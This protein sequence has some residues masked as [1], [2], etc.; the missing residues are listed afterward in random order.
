MI[1]DRPACATAPA[2]AER[3]VVWP[4]RSQLRPDRVLKIGGLTP[5][6]ATDYPGHLSAVIFVQGCPWRCHY[7]HNPHLQPR[8]RHSPLSWPDL[9]DWLERRRGLLDAVVFCGGEPLMDPM[10]P[11]AVLEAKAMGFKIA[12]HSGGSYPAPL[13]KILPYLDWIGLDIKTGFD[14]YAD[15]TCIPK[16]GDP[17]RDSLAHMLQSGVSYE[18]RTTIHPDLHNDAGILALARQLAAYGVQHYALQRFRP[19]GCDNDALKATMYAGTFP[20]SDTLAEIAGLFP[21]FV[22]R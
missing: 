12:L 4:G 6:S 15:I 2:T 8:T 7:C 21:D 3:P 19:D 14:D 20:S 22:V 10:L 16:S 1:S 18:C 5:F 17:V 13:R 11:E 9:R